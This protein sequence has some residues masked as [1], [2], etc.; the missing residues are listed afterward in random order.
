MVQHLSCQRQTGRKAVIRRRRA[1]YMA[2]RRKLTS[3]RSWQKNLPCTAASRLRALCGH[4]EPRAVGWRSLVTHSAYN[5]STINY[6]AASPFYT[7]EQQ[8]GRPFVAIRQG[9]RRS[10]SMSEATSSFFAG[11]YCTLRLSRSVIHSMPSTIR[12]ITRMMVEALWY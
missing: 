5:R 6:S 2:S 3:I 9:C 7:K 8:L 10:S 11:H 4:T 1:I 12:N